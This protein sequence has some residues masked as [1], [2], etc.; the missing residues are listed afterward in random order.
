[1]TALE[2][3]RTSE[4]RSFGL[5]LGAAF[6]LIFGALP[7]VRA[8]RLVAWPF[9]LAAALWMVALAAPAAL[10]GLHALWTRLG[11]ALGWLN[12]R[13]ILSIMFF[14]WVVPAGLVMRLLGRDQLGLR[15]GPKVESYRVAG[16]KRPPESMERPY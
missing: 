4:L 2:K 7:L 12:T 10:S 9:A 3:S 1:M 14:V 8:H 11:H 5:V 13:I 15:L 6:A 16:R